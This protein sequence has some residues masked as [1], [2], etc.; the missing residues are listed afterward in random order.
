LGA[1]TASGQTDGKVPLRIDL[2]SGKR[3]AS[4]SLTDQKQFEKEE[5]RILDVLSQ[6]LAT[7]FPNPNRA[8]CPGSAILEG[9]ASHRVPLSE[10]EKWLDHFGSCS[11]CFQ[12]FKAIRKKLRKRRW[13]RLGGGLPVVL[14]ALA[15]WFALRSH[16]G[17]GRD[18]T[19][20]LDVRGYSVER[21][22]ESPSNQPP[23]ELRRSTR[24]LVLYLPIGSREGSY[25]LAMLNQI[26]NELFHGGG[27]AQLENHVVV[28]R[29]DIDLADLPAGL[30]SL[31]L[32][33]RG[34]QWT[35]FPVRVF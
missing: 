11:P 18:Q 21:G 29:T 15:L 35:R 31:G 34:F 5:R 28:L 19:A 9:I 14:L 27:I 22:G 12:E 10:A 17:V 13:F 20:I 4:Q 25:D 33:P 24:H 2:T 6:R 1:R 30:Y 26:G 3:R 23:L 32:R 8:G 16:Y 7:E